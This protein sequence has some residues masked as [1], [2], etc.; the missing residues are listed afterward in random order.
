M[1]STSTRSALGSSS[2]GGS[3]EA[4]LGGSGTALPGGCADYR[5]L[6]PPDMS[7]IPPGP[8]LFTGQAGEYVLI[9]PG[10]HTGW[11]GAGTTTTAKHGSAGPWSPPD[12]EKPATPTPPVN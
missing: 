6:D 1:T 5:P 7:A 9:G 11:G 3:H 10:V 4:L 8:G 2:D 12:A